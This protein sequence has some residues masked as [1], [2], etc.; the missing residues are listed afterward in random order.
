MNNA[1][2][3]WEEWNEQLSEE[4]R[5]YSLYKILQSMDGKLAQ[6]PERYNQCDQRFRKLENRKWID[7]ASSGLGGVIG[8]ILAVIGK[9]LIR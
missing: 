3:S 1:M 5:Q 2:P 7:R 6:C 4:Q 9:T 8:G